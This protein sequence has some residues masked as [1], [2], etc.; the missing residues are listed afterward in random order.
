MVRFPTNAHM[1]LIS[2]CG[3]GC[4][5][6]G[7][8]TIPNTDSALMF[9]HHFIHPKWRSKPFRNKD[10][11]P[12]LL[13]WPLNP[14]KPEPPSPQNV[15]FQIKSIH[16]LETPNLLTE[17]IDRS[18]QDETL[19]HTCNGKQIPPKFI[20]IKRWNGISQKKKKKNNY[21][22]NWES[23]PGHKKSPWGKWIEKSSE[24]YVLPLHHSTWFF[25]CRF[26]M[27]LH[28]HEKSPLCLDFC[29]RRIVVSFPS[30][31]VLHIY[32]KK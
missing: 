9:I 29:T 5:T 6:L 11:H 7:T 18:W 2:G 1:P 31:R 26:G 21:R 13:W 23:N 25:W 10:L 32:K 17:P 28:F 24:S 3:E 20:A 12:Q 30:D 4:A 27:S 16:L 8:Y 19:V 14:E 15:Y 22:S